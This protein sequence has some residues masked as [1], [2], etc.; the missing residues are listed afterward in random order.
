MSVGVVR[1][2]LISMEEIHLRPGEIL[3]IARH[4]LM[5]L[6]YLALVLFL[7]V[8]NANGT[9]REVP[10]E[11]RGP[12]YIL[13]AVVGVTLVLTALRIA[14][15]AAARGRTVRVSASPLFFLAGMLGLYC[16]E[17]LSILVVDSQPMGFVQG[18]LLVLFYY[19]MIEIAGGLAVHYIFPRALAEIRGQAAPPVPMPDLAPTA[20]ANLPT[21]PTLPT[22]QNTSVVPLRPV[23]TI[24]I[25][26][27]RFLP[28]DIQRI[29]AEGNYVRIVTAKDRP[30]L[31]GPFS[32]VVARM[33]EAL[34][35]QVGRSHWVAAATVLGRRREGRDLYLLLSDGSDLRVSASRR[36]AVKAWLAELEAA[37]KTG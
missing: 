34:G 32:S 8:A 13:G 4:R 16:G 3:Q 7:I 1:F 15:L 23:D 19:V 22:V 35:R 14:E 29:E 30:L 26:N 2:R 12:V 6:F 9:A 20:P 11:L 10:I 28:T 17:A 5:L 37:Q 24:R 27:R 36:D 18:L 25:G 21:L 33:P 31:P